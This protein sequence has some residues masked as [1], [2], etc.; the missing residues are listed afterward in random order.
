MIQVEYKDKKGK[1][2]S[3]G[4]YIRFYTITPEFQEVGCIPSEMV[5]EQIDTIIKV[6]EIEYQ[7]C[8]DE[9]TILNLPIAHDYTKDELLELFDLSASIP[10]EEFKECI[11]DPICE[12]IGKDLSLDE[13]LEEI[14]GFEIM[15][16]KCEF[17]KD[18]NVSAAGHICANC[19]ND[20]QHI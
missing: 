18:A 19:Q 11:L 13:C 7:P 12:V 10:D 14:S 16:H 15:S 6:H 9:Y 17:C 20:I 3:N 1:A 8:I 2:L 5:Q 4:D